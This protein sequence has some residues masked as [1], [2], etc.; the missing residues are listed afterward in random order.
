MGAELLRLIKIPDI[1]ICLTDAKVPRSLQISEFELVLSKTD[2][3][4]INLFGKRVLEVFNSIN[5]LSLSFRD[6]E[7]LKCFKP[8][9]T[10]HFID[11]SGLHHFFKNLM[12]RIKIL[13]EELLGAVRSC[14]KPLTKN[15]D[16]TIQTFR[17]YTDL[18]VFFIY[19]QLPDLIE[20]ENLEMFSEI[21]Q[22][23]LY[24]PNWAMQTLKNWL[25][26]LPQ[27]NFINLITQLQQIISVFVADENMQF[28]NQ[29]QISF[30]SQ[31]HVPIKQPNY[32]ILE[33]MVNLLN[34]L[35]EASAIGNK[36]PESLFKN[37]SISNDLTVILQYKKWNKVY[38]FI[39][40][41]YILLFLVR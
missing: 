22:V 32:G 1:D 39:P 18:R 35:H 33:P 38:N 40:S 19:F 25:A 29:L 10:Q 9:E 23:L 21:V 2:E 27:E 41:I 31:Y 17:T 5:A 11:L 13:K 37:S 16:L 26:S 14:L 34:L 24:L 8:S 12:P 7:D 30:L 6:S 15:N 20:Y 36:V 3:I 4:N 28:E